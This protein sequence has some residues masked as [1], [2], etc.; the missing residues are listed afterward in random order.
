LGDQDGTCGVV[1]VDEGC[2]GVGGCRAVNVTGPGEPAELVERRKFDS[3]QE[4]V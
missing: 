2:G 4:D 1:P 3:L